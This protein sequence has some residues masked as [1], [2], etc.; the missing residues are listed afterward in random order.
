MLV[1]IFEHGTR[2]GKAGNPSEF[3]LAEAAPARRRFFVKLEAP[4]VR[5]L[6]CE[7]GEQ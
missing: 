3:G 1:R 4:P 5:A 7:H 2:K 6:P